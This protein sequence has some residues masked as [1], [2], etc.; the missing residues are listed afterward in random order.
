[1]KRVGL[2]VGLVLTAVYILVILVLWGSKAWCLA[3]NELG[4]FLAGVFT[5]L[6]FGWLVYGYFLQTRELGLQ[7]EELKHQREELEE[8]RKTL[9]E[10]VELLK[11]RDE[12]EYKRSVPCLELQLVTAEHGPEKGFDPEKAFEG[13][14]WKIPL[15]WEISGWEIE[16]SGGTVGRLALLFEGN[17]SQKKRRVEMRREL[18]PHGNQIF[19][20][21]ITPP[22][23]AVVDRYEA[24]FTSARSERFYQCWEIRR[25]KGD[26]SS[27][28]EETMWERGRTTGDP[29]FE[30][31]ELTDGPTH[32]E[33]A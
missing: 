21:T 12:A 19:K 2:C 1:M 7:R 20:F 10:Q 24:H 13:D 18:G 27:E 16:N 11:K 15:D 30:V 9:S 32:L 22:A 26:P 6:A 31:K 4:D 5:P 23:L 3:P 17:D 14:R 33:E 29:P 25:T 28:S 8:T